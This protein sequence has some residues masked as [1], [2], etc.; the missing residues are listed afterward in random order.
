MSGTT[1]IVLIVFIA[2]GFSVMS[3]MFNQYL[4]QQKSQQNKYN[5]TLQKELDTLKERVATLEKIV[6]DE[7]YALKEQFKKL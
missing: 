7:S 1:M 3:K 6:T 2:V 5:D 4:A